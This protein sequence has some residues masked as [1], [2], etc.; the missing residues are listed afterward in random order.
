MRFARVFLAAASLG[1]AVPALA[2][3]PAPAQVSTL[4]DSTPRTLI[5]TAYAP[6]W[7]AMAAVITH[8]Q[9]LKINDREIVLG[10]LSGHPVILMSSGVSMVNAAMNTQ[11]ALDHFRVRRI[12]FSGVAGASIPRCRLAMFLCPNTGGSIWR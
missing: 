3:A 6:E 5:L 9:K 1:V 11:L 10:T 4:L 2:A 12:V 7:E 8:G